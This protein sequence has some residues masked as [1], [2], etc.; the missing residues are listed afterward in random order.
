VDRYAEEFARMALELHEQPSVEETVEG[1]LAYAL[2]AVDCAYAGVILVQGRSRVQ[3]V[4]A[5]NDVVAAL[6]RAQLESGVG[7]DVELIADRVSVL[8]ADTET[9][10]RWPAWS[11]AVADA[12]VRSM[13]G[14]RMHTSS[15]TIGSLNLYDPRPNRFTDDDR[16][17]AHILARH[18]AVAMSSARRKANLWL[19]MDTRRAIGEAQGILMERFAIDAD[20]AFAVLRRYSQDHNVKL[21]E[22]AERLISTRRLPE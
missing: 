19:A 21:K 9:D 8:V 6:D 2:R 16:D 20:Q 15:A 1:V 3:T 14:I 12:G 7:P 11:R 4:A 18:A 5:T 22:V 17:V 10:D 13:L